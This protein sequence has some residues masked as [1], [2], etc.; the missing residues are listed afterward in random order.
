MLV[1]SGPPGGASLFDEHRV[2]LI[3]PRTTDT[4]LKALLQAWCSHE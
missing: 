4:E 2:I 3:P 1:C